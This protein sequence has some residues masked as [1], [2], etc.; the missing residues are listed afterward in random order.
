MRS[1]LPLYV[2][3]TRGIAVPM[4]YESV[5]IIASVVTLLVAARVIMEAK[6]GPTHGV[7][8]SPRLKPTN[9]PLINPSFVLLFG[10]N[11]V[12]FEKNRSETF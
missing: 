9:N 4:E 6:I 2:I 11:F 12:N 8:R 7:Q 5:M 1:S 10:A 3:I